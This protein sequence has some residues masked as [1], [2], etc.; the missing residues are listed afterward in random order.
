MLI[1]EPQ[2]PAELSTVTDAVLQHRSGEGG[3]R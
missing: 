1:D 3:S 2:N